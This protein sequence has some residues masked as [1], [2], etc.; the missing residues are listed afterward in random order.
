VP[1]NPIGAILGPLG[2]LSIY[3]SRKR[4][5][6]PSWIIFLVFLAFTLTACKPPCPQTIPEPNNPVDTPAET[7][8]EASPATQTGQTTLDATGT[9]E[10]PV[11][12]V[13]T[14]TP[15]PYCASYVNERYDRQAAVDFVTD[16]RNY[17]DKAVFAKEYEI[18]GNDCA[19]F[20]S[21]ALQEGGL[22]QAATWKP[23][24]DDWI[25]TQLLFDFLLQPTVGFQIIAE[26][27]NIG[28]YRTPSVDDYIK[29]RENNTDVSSFQGELPKKYWSSYMTDIGSAQKGDLVFYSDRSWISTGQNGEIVTWTHVAMITGWGGQTSYAWPTTGTFQEPLVSDHDGP[30]VILAKNLPRSMGDTDGNKIE[31]VIV[32][33]AP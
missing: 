21:Y 27:T 24:T 15:C 13:T 2:L 4:G 8:P 23:G 3:Y 11:E 6:K 18:Y 10:S 26:F 19:N 16:S 25:N 1:W 20:M 30:S 9:A 14:A 17:K 33:H 5:K 28:D 32:L 7:T 22:K 12:S 29:L 31:K